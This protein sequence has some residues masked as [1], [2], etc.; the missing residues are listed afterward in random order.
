M[1][2]NPNLK[3]TY[4]RI[5][6]T[7]LRCPYSKLQDVGQSRLRNSWTELMFFTDTLQTAISQTVSEHP[8]RRVTW[9]SANL[10]TKKTVIN[11]VKKKWEK[12]KGSKVAAHTE[13][14]EIVT[15]LRSSRWT[16]MRQSR[17]YRAAREGVR[18]RNISCEGRS[19]KGSSRETL[20]KVNSLP[21]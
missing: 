19:Y 4:K 11:I 10:Q 7:Y 18:W 5:Y 17:K 8:A 9:R 14:Q 12:T 3:T 1:T 20:I 16:R 21:S 6:S 13:K 2:R 15:K